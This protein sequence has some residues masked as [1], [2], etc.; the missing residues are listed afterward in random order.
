MRLC[1][2]PDGSTNPKYKLLCFI[3]TKKIC[4]EKNALAFNR[5]RCCHLVLCLQS[6]PFHCTCLGHLGQCNRDWIV[7]IFCR[8]T[9][10]GQ[11]KYNSDCHRHRYLWSCV[12]VAGI[13][14]LKSLPMFMSL[15]SDIELLALA[16]LGNTAQTEAIL[17][18]SMCPR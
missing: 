12:T 15:Y 4:K 11:G 1:Q 14:A 10:S 5:D 9:Q 2:P 3:T 8:T 16:T 6:I 18:V 17:I 7:S 13:F